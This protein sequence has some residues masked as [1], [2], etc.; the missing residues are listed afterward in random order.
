M[1]MGVKAECADVA[2]DREKEEGAKKGMKATRLVVLCRRVLK[3]QR[4]GKHG[5]VPLFLQASALSSAR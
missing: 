1:E 2:V 4:G 3:S 5:L